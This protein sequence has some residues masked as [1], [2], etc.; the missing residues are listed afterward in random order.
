M[1]NIHHFYGPSSMMISRRSVFDSFFCRFP[2][3]VL[4]VE[5][6]DF[7]AQHLSVLRLFHN[8]FLWI[9]VHKGREKGIRFHSFVWEA[10][11]SIMSL[12][13]RVCTIFWILFHQI[14]KTPINFSWL[15][16]QKRLMPSRYSNNR[17][18]ASDVAV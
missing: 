16:I 4:D 5:F 12:M 13:Y 18:Y 1:S 8:R 14:K 2:L 6:Y 3:F 17:G 9:S 11:A 10:I 7:T 15:C